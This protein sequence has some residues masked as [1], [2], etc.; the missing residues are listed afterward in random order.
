MTMWSAVHWVFLFVALLAFGGT[1]GRNTDEIVPQM[2]QLQHDSN[3][4]LT[5]YSQSVGGQGCNMVPG[6]IARDIDVWC[7]S[8]NDAHSHS[9]ELVA[10][11]G[12]F[13]LECYAQG[14][15]FFAED[16]FYNCTWAPSIPSNYRLLSSS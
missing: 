14:D 16:F 4:T 15:G 5:V 3:V 6:T 1:I 13:M 10:A 8:C 11:L 7:N 2:W 9:S 12:F